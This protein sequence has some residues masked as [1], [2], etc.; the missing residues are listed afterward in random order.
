[1]TRIGRVTVKGD[2]TRP[3]QCFQIIVENGDITLSVWRQV[4]IDMMPDTG[5]RVMFERIY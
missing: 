4:W 3:V 1:M 2:L 5:P